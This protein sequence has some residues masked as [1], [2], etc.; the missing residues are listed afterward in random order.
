MNFLAHIY[1]S[2]ENE[3]IRIGNFIADW[4]KGSEFKKFPED[5]Q[6]GIL[7]HRSIDSYT[8]SHPTVRKSKNRF[9][10][11]YH[12][13]AGVLI[14]VFYDHFLAMDWDTFSPVPLQD[15]NNRVKASLLKEIQCFPADLQDFIPKFM[16]FG[17]MDLYV[18]IDGIDKVLRGMVSNTSLPDKTD[19]AIRIFRENYSDFRLEFYDYF[20]QLMHYVEEKF[21]ITVHSAHR[22]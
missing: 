18:S 19:D 20:P 9:S 21:Q 4:I 1:L 5:I 10:E 8:D 16:N 7:I 11:K 17:W 13:Y 2:G 22:K 15:Y 12:K 6:K 14:D 3:Q